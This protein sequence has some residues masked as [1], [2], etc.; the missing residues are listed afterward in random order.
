MAPLTLG[1]MLDAALG[2]SRDGAIDFEQLHHLLNG[3]LLHLG[4]RELLVQENGEPLEGAEESPFLFLKDLKQRLEANEKQI[5]EVQTLCQELR[6]EV[7]EMKAEQ[8][9]VAEDMQRILENFDVD[10]FQNMLEDL[11]KQL[12]DSVMSSINDMNQG[13]QGWMKDGLRHTGSW[14]DPG[15]IVIGNE[16]TLLERTPITRHRDTPPSSPLSPIAK[17]QG[18][19]KDVLEA[20]ESGHPVSSREN[21]MAQKV[22]Q[23]GTGWNAGRKGL[24]QS[25]AGRSDAG[26]SDAGRSDTGRSDVGR[27]GVGRKGVGQSARSSDMGRKDTE[28]N[29]VGQVKDEETKMR[30]SKTPAHIQR[31]NQNG[32]FTASGMHPGA[33]GNLLLVQEQELVQDHPGFQPLWIPAENGKRLIKVPSSEYSPCDQLVQLPGRHS[34]IAPSTPPPS[35]GLSGRLPRALKQEHREQAAEGYSRGTPRYCGGRHTSTYAGQPMEP[36]LPDPNKPGVIE[37]VGKDGVVYRGRSAPEEDS[38]LDSSLQK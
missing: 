18:R 12:L 4:L 26:R 34:D 31:K 30:I 23:N 29:G 33:P 15:L 20:K 14:D 5:A 2:S 13:G 3:L 35:A 6:E 37:L 32:G 16:I 27:K 24:G 10:N 25:D 28:Q 1:Q 8:S 21:D 11:R 19:E 22:G 7:V 38:A 9:R 17:T 36:L